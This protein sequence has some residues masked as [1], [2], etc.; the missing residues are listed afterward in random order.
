VTGP[1]ALNGLAQAHG[2]DTAF[3]WTAGIFAAGAVIG[4][5]LFRNGPLV[6]ARPSSPVPAQAPTVPAKTEDERA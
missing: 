5:A 4:G 3:W 6:L 2:Y 1:Q